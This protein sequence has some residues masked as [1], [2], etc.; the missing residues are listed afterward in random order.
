MFRPL[1][2]GTPY[3]PLIFM[4]TT[5]QILIAVLVTLTTQVYAGAPSQQLMDASQNLNEAIKNV[6]L[7]QVIPDLASALKVE[8]SIVEKGMV[9]NK[10]KLS[11]LALA[12]FVA[13]KTSKSV[14][15]F[16]N[17]SSETEWVDVLAQNKISDSDV[18]EY[19]DGLQTEVAFLMLDHRK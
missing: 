9:E 18:Q 1:K 11:D 15:S 12:K 17:V 19:L 2:H 7:K 4:K 13:D 3:A 10:H 8:S 6:E 14:D 16:M 5:I